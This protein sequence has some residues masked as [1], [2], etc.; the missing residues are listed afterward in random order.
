MNQKILTNKEVPIELQFIKTCTIKTL[1]VG[2]YKNPLTDQH[3]VISTFPPK[4][5]FEYNGTEFDLFNKVTAAVSFH[6][7]Y[8]NYSHYYGA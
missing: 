6:E 8:R 2:L 5:C 4:F 1:N 7:T 3:F